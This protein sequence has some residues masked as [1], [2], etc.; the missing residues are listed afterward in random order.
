MKKI[1]I[2]FV[3]LLMTVLAT[4]NVFAQTSIIGKWK[5]N[6][7][8]LKPVAGKKFTPEQAKS[9]T[10]SKKA[11]L[12]R[13][14]GTIWVFDENAL[15]MTDGSD[16]NKEYVRTSDYTFDESKSQI[17]ISE[18]GRKIEWSAKIKGNQLIIEMSGGGD[19]SGIGKIVQIF[20]KQ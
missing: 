8:D 15:T 6:T 19:K 18:G 16:K 1:T 7:I 2:L 5:F 10:E 11:M 12:P 14:E 13:F 3:M 17:S 9:A 20:D 4:N